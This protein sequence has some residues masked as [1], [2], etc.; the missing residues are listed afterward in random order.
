MD[1]PK[2]QQYWGYAPS[3]PNGDV[4][5]QL[6]GRPL[7]FVEE[8]AQQYGGLVGLLLGGERVVLVSDPVCARWDGD[9]VTGPAFASQAQR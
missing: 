3:G 2:T 4:A 7:A 5:L 1:F 6:L 9:G 8:A